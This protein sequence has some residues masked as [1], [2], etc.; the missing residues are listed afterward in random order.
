MRFYTVSGGQGTR[1][2]DG[3]YCPYPQDF[4]P[5]I[6][7]PSYPVD[8]H[9]RVVRGGRPGDMMFAAFNVVSQRFLDVLGECQ[10]TGYSP[11][12][13]RVVLA[14][15]RNAECAGYFLIKVLGRALL[16]AHRSGLRHFDSGAVS[17]WDSTHIDESTWDG[18]DVFAVGT[19]RESYGTQMNV[20]ERVAEGLR[21]SKL[22]NVVLTR[23][24]E[25]SV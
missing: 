17:G 24:D 10:A 23:N 1:F 3:E 9:V 19:R 13:I 20:V 11:R 21:R 18:S 6:L 8:V 22:R 16:D 25:H 12:P 5:L 15:R 14:H 2:Y 4:G 7:D